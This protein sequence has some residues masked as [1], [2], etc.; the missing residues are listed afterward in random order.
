[1]WWPLKSIDRAAKE[2]ADV[3]ARKALEEARGSLSVWLAVEGP[4]VAQGATDEAK[5]PR[6]KKAAVA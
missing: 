6:R 3:T 2:M 5:K 1:M 4:T